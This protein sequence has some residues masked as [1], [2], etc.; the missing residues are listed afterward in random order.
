MKC[1]AHPDT[2]TGLSCGRC[3]TPICPRCLVETPV[4]A[5]CRKCANVRRLPTYSV[6][7]V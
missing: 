1:A 6:S 2:E 5:R 7:R 4:G 3:D